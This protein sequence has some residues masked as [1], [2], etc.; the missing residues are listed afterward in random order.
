M[1][2]MPI[3]T[4]VWF[5]GAMLFAIPLLTFISQ[6]LA[7]TFARPA[8]AESNVAPVVHTQS[9]VVLV[10]AHNE[11]LGISDTINEL[12]RQADP[13]V[14]ICVVADNCTDATAE[15]ARAAGAEVFE[16]SN[17]KNRGKGFAL[18]FGLLQL[19]QNPP[20]V[21][22]IVDADCRMGE[23]ALQRL[24]ARCVELKRPVQARYVMNL[25]PLA[26][27]KQ[28]IGQFAWEVKTWMRSVGS[29]RLGIPNQLLGTG[30]AFPWDGL[31]R[32]DIASGHLAEDAKLGV[33]LTLLGMAPV[34]LPEIQVVS[35]FP[36]TQKA[37]STQHERWERGH[38]SIIREFV[39]RLL[40]ESASQ[41]RRDLA[42]FALDFLVPPLAMLAAVLLLWSLAGLILSAIS[43][44]P[45]PGVTSLVLLLV[46]AGGIGTAWHQVG[47]QS[48]SPGDL[49][50]V[51]V[52]V[53]RKLPLYAKA[54]LGKAAP[55]WIRTDRK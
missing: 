21:V 55:G 35:Q 17:L 6:V 22:V 41:R 28:R 26:N 32:V 42:L 38:L 18:D 44:N 54:L 25:P 8:E 34:F 11:E 52:Y 19:A 24:I 16:R 47:R 45:V 14:R 39:P 36:E 1:T 43:H 50:L 23:G 7:Y 2:P 48:V 3:V 33:D 37:S 13:G 20:D 46:F 15:N 10:P 40:R 9:C 53:I 30:M 49:F 31:S 51:P 29:L 12:R 4:M 27:P 5:V